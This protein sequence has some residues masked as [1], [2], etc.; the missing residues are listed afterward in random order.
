[1][2]WRLQEEVNLGEGFFSFKEREHGV[3]G[4]GVIVLRIWC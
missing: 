4:L 1:M 3:A 2:R